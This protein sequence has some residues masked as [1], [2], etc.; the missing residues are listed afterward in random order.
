MYVEGVQARIADV[1]PEHRANLEYPL[2]PPELNT[3]EKENK[4]S[5]NI[6]LE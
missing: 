5:D 1:P 6:P 4:I 3:N 2:L